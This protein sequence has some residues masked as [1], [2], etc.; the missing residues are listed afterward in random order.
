MSLVFLVFVFQSNSAKVHLEVETQHAQGK[1]NMLRGLGL[2]VH[3][4]K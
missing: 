1:P 4:F 2:L 3:L